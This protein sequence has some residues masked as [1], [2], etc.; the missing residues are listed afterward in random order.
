MHAGIPADYPLREG[1]WLFDLGLARVEHRLEGRRLRYRVLDGE[2]AGL[3]EAVPFEV[4]RIASALF[5]VSWQEGDGTTVVHLEDFGRNAFE[6]C[7]TLPQLALLRLRGT[8][9]RQPPGTCA[10]TADLP[11]SGG[12]TPGG[13]PA[14]TDRGDIR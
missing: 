9:R 2:R 7:V 1:P 12:A 13:A 5:W 4:R 6:S 10:A 3:S 14:R 11:G 8:M